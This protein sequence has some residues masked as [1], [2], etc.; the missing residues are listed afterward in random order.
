MQAPSLKI[1]TCVTANLTLAA[2]VGFGPIKVFVNLSIE[3]STCFLRM[4]AWEYFIFGCAGQSGSAR[5]YAFDRLMVQHR[6]LKFFR[7]PI[8]CIT[9]PAH[10]DVTLL[11]LVFLNMAG[12]TGTVS[13]LSWEEV[14]CAIT[15]L[16]GY[17]SHSDNIHYIWSVTLIYV[18]LPSMDHAITSILNTP[19]IH[20]LLLAD[21]CLFPSRAT[22]A[23]SSAHL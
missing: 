9:Q 7:T 2:S 10:H 16:D 19:Y 3:P 20:L 23:T 11:S 13:I 18:L 6:C 8:L 5:V 4:Q 21:I 15:A 1:L 14:Y 12:L 17:P 22:R